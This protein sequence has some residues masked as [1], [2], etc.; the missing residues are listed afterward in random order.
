[1]SSVKNFTQHPT[2]KGIC[3]VSNPS[4]EITRFKESNKRKLHAL[5]FY[6]KYYSVM[7]RFCGVT[8]FLYFFM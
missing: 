8:Q 5:L 4:L 7:N 2:S 3:G 1:M 6:K